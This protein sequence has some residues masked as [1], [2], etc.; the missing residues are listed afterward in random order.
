[1]ND[2]RAHI[3]PEKMEKIKKGTLKLIDCY[4]EMVREFGYDADGAH[5]LSM[6][7]TS[8]M[9]NVAMDMDKAKN[10]LALQYKVSNKLTYRG[11]S[12][13]SYMD[14]FP[15]LMKHSRKTAATR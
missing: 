12:F 11:M 9:T 6:I 8:F 14:L 15:Y 2:D 7:V 3:A 10:L 13:D 1:M 5:L 4:Q